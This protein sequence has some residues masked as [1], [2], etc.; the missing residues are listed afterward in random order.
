MKYYRWKLKWEDGEGIDFARIVN[1]DVVRV[2]PDFAT[3]DLQDSTT[4]IYGYALLGSITPS[5]LSD[6]SVE[7][8]TSSEILS[9]AQALNVDAVISADGRV[10]FPPI[11]E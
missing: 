6:W 1:N 3:G 2:E 8:V 5:D 10:E 9:A 11:E 7:E 4:W